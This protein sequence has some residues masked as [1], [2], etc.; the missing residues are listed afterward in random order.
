MTLQTLPDVD[1]V[2]GALLAAAD[3]ARTSWI[4]IE[5]PEFLGMSMAMLRIMEARAAAAPKPF[6]FTETQITDLLAN[7]MGVNV[8][9]VRRKGI[10]KWLQK[11]V[12]YQVVPNTGPGSN[13]ERKMYA[14]HV[15]QKLLQDKQFC[16]TFRKK[17]KAAI[18]MATTP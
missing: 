17:K 9:T 11:D 6:P 2:V 12:D 7:A 3:Y 1:Q 14:Q 10:S 8:A 5:D 18:S 16:R 13:G 4:G 15:L